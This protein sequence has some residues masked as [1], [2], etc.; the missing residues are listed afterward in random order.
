MNFKSNVIK[1][2]QQ[3]GFTVS[4][5]KRHC[6]YELISVNPIGKEAGVRVKA[7]GHITRPERIKLLSHKM[8]IYI[9]SEKYSGDPDIH[10]ISIARLK[11]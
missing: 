5:A 7:H 6:G 1:K 4:H 10:D 2:L 3:E 9:A 8:P 11:K